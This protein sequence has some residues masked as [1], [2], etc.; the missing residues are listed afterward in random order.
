[1]TY[2]YCVVRSEHAPR[3]TRG[4]KGVP[5]AGAPRVIDAGA[6]L[7]LVISHAPSA[8]WSERSIAARLEDLPWVSRC[9]LA[10][11]A[12]VERFLGAGGLVPMKLFTL[13][14]DDERAIAWV[15]RDRS[16]LLRLLARLGGREEWGCK[17]ALDERRAIADAEARAGAGGRPASGA[18][19][20]GR[21]RAIRD[22]RAEI[23]GGARDTA[24]EIF[25][26][27]ATHA[28]DARRK[29][30]AQ[31]PGAARVLLDASFLVPAGD[32]AAWRRTVG[33]AAREL[34]KSGYEL[35]LTGP[36]PPYHF[37]GDGS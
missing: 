34:A 16:R 13:F 37:V 25:D 9:A 8:T 1:M 27:L 30:P 6:G 26:R 20:L 19:F 33:V 4:M 31:T 32:R 28:G 12:I 22:A 3:V 17:L 7:W 10:H 18:A 11:E 23:T 15:A 14:A 24:D 2:V 21:K 35:T 29:T 36:W 5:G